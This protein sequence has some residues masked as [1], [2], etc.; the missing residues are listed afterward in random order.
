MGSLGLA[1]GAMDGAERRRSARH[2]LG[3]TAE[4][5][6]GPETVL[7]VVHDVSAHGMGL[8]M[9]S[10]V[11]VKL[12]DTLWILA[13]A[14]ASYAITATVR[15]VTDGLVGVE[16]DEILA[17]DALE[18]VEQLAITDSNDLVSE[19]LDVNPNTEDLT[20]PGA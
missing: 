2:L 9:P 6:V 5:H 10:D 14:V 15:R 11:P 3:V 16:L 1:S 19:S 20:S 4:V 17:G 8:V 13:T 7:A 12:G 18:K